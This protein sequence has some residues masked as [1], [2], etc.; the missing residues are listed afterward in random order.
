MA[1]AFPKPILHLTKTGD[2]DEYQGSSLFGD[3]TTVRWLPE[4]APAMMATL[5]SSNMLVAMVPF[6]IL[7]KEEVAGG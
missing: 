6:C 2:I 3:G 7:F 4:D 5:F 1:N